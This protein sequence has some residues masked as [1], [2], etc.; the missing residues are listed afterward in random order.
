MHEKRLTARL[1]SYWNLVRKD[2]P[3]P[4]YAQF[5]QGAIDDLWQKCMLL[6]MQPSASKPVFRISS[7]GHELTGLLGHDLVG[8]EVSRAALRDFG[9]G[10]IATK[11]DDVVVACSPVFDDGKF[12]NKNTNKIVKYRACLLPFGAD[13]EHI[14]HILMGLSWREF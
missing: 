14:S 9:G 8:R 5:N 7:V 2:A 11:V 1:E 6:A 10:K 13:S 12:V 4:Q 3:L